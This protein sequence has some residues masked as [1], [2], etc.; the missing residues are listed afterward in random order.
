M[1]CKHLRVTVAVCLAL[2][3]GLPIEAPLEAATRKGDKFYKQAQAAE[4]KKDWDLALQL[5]RQAVDEDGRD[6]GY[7]I[8]LTRARFEASSLHV[9]RGQKSRADGNLEE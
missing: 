2:L 6:T 4:V 5:Y 9:A 8:G 1:I 3:V 7:L